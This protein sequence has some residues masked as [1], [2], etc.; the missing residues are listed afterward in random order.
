MRRISRIASAD[1]L[2]EPARRPDDLDL[3]AEWERLRGRLETGEAVTVEVAVE[4]A[5][6]D[7]FR[8][9]ASFQVVPDSPVEELGEREELLLDFAPTTELRADDLREAGDHRVHGF[10]R[11]DLRLAHG[12][13]FRVCHHSQSLMAS[14]GSRV[15]ARQAGTTDSATNGPTTANASAKS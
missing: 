10:E 3:A 4:A 2:D 9:L 7:L 6:L 15:A 5:E 13:F 1:L 11:E 12:R 8:R 14:M